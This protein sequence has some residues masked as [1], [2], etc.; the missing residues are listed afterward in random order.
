MK[1]KNCGHEITKDMK[2]HKKLS[3]FVF[4]HFDCTDGCKEK[5]CSCTNPEPEIKTED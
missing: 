5:G 1:C 2:Q 4:P 3:T